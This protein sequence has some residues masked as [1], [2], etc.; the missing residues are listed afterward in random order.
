M[1]LQRRSCT[2]AGHTLCK[3]PN[4]AHT[5]QDTCGPSHPPKSECTTAASSLLLK[6]LCSFTIVVGAARAAEAAQRM[7]PALLLQACGLAS[8]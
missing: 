6:E 3:T 4:R 2:K 7:V 1:P 8:R 5:V